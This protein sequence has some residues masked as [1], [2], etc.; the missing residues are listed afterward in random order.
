MSLY[1]TPNDSFDEQTACLFFD[2]QKNLPLPVTNVT[3]EFFSRQ[4]WIFNFGVHDLR[5]G[6]AVM[7]TYSETYAHK[8]PNE[9][10]SCLRYYI[11][12][13][14]SPN[15]T[16]LRL[17]C[18]NSAGQNKNK[19]LI[20]YLYSLQ[21][22]FDEII[23]TFPVVGHSRMPIN[24]DFAH[25]EKA[26]RKHDTFHFPSDWTRLIRSSLRNSPFQLIYLEHPLTDD[27]CDDGTPIARVFNFKSSLEPYL[28]PVTGISNVKAFK[29]SQNGEILA[30]ESTA[31][32]FTRKYYIRKPF[33]TSNLLIQVTLL[34]ALA[35]NDFV[36]LK[37]PKF[38]NVMDLLKNV[39]ITPDK[40]FYSSLQPITIVQQADKSDTD[41][42]E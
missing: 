3:K 14:V 8:G 7:F 20:A 30:R 35:F 33:V 29:F 26:K 32:A 18:D 12:N 19:Y 15:I 2:Y 42:E 38:N 25:I 21:A 17:F 37:V 10:I 9:V 40:V 6:K 11:D 41:N 24:K 27:L 4:L 31:G 23:I 22:R 1:V 13:H 5:T 39:H 28:R 16:K 36:L 34:K